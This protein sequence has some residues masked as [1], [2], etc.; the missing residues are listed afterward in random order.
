L[1]H[2][3]IGIYKDE[4]LIA[5]QIVFTVIN[6]LFSEEAFLNNYMRTW[7]KS[8]PRRCPMRK[9]K[10]NCFGVTSSPWLCFLYLFQ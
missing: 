4:S 9:R 2:L 5:L 7:S 1:I 10:R 3:E 6:I 8:R